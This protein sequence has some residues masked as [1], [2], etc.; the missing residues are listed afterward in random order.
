MDDSQRARD[1]LE[2]EEDDEFREQIEEAFK[3]FDTIPKPKEYEQYGYYDGAYS[4]M[5]LDELYSNM[6]IAFEL[7]E[8]DDKY[9]KCNNLRM[10]ANTVIDSIDGIDKYKIEL[11]PEANKELQKIQAELR[12]LLSADKT[13]MQAI[14]DRI[15]TYNNYAIDIWNDYLTNVNDAQNNEFRWVVHNLTKGELQGDFRDKYMSTSLITNNAMGLYGSANYGL[16]IKP[17]H[18]VSASHKD[19]YTNNF[20]D[21]DDDL[22]T[23]K[24][25]IKLPQ[26]VEETCVEKTIEENGE[27]LNYDT[28]AIYSE[29]V[30]DEY[31]I[32]G[33]YYISNGEHEL[34]RNYDRARKVAEEKG[35]PLIERDISKYRAEHGLDPM[36]DKTKRDFCKS[37]LFGCCNGY[38][39]LIENFMSYGADFVN[40]N[41]QE[42]YDKYM[43]LKQQ[44]N[45]SIED[46]LKVF[47]EIVENDLHF[48]E[49]AKNV[50]ELYPSQA[51][52]LQQT[53]ELTQDI[54]TESTNEKVEEYMK[55]KQEIENYLG[56]K[57]ESHIEKREAETTYGEDYIGDTEEW[58]LGQKVIRNNRELS[59]S[60]VKVL[61]K[62]SEEALKRLLKDSINK[63]DLETATTCHII[64]QE[65]STF[66]RN[67]P[68][69]I[70]LDFEQ[71]TLLF[72]YEQE[73]R[74]R[75]EQE[76]K[77]KAAQEAREK[78]EQKAREKAEQEAREKV[79]RE[80]KEKSEQ[81]ARAKAE[82]EAK[83]KVAQE[84]RAKAEQEAKEKA[85][86]EARTKAEQEAKEKL[87]QEEREK[88]EQ[89]AKEQAKREEKL[90]I[91]RE[92]EKEE[93][94]KEAERNE[95]IEQEWKEYT[96]W[97]NIIAQ[98]PELEGLMKE[99]QYEQFSAEVQGAYSKRFNELK[100]IVDELPEDIRVVFDR[101]FQKFVSLGSTENISQT[102][103][104]E[105]TDI[106]NE[107]EITQ[108]E[109]D[110]Q[111]QENMTIGVGKAKIN[112]FGEIIRDESTKIEG[113][114]TI[115]VEENLQEDIMTFEPP[116]SEKIRPEEE[117]IRDE[118]S[119]KP[120]N[121]DRKTQKKEAVT[122]DLWM[123]R[124][125]GWYNAIDRVSQNVK[126]KFIQM[127][128][129]IVNAIRDRLK[130]RTT[131]KQEDVQM[132]DTNE[133]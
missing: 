72:E 118:I 22:Y 121:T 90:R 91:E 4:D 35:L 29:I 52:K 3:K 130:E 123:S 12:I 131:Q 96:E 73:A 100:A 24:P 81:E 50:K 2:P 13:D 107:Q 40:A 65:E 80:A 116:Q 55:S 70:G 30:V 109:T 38:D 47:A 16:I 27:M 46:I 120:E 129:D 88:A 71:G 45:F 34:A 79:E 66:Y 7:R 102:T 106:T 108:Q 78:A 69:A 113:E 43:K 84:A 67:H 10:I 93:K 5:E 92:K 83:E 42:F 104:K 15:D 56:I 112:E 95:R 77:E 101:E 124:F 21:D 132:Q 19:T 25:A 54:M 89:E 97:E 33:V 20:R 85:E 94:K 87:E 103:N 51:D 9:Y 61:S 76:A 115:K 57:I 11:T 8:L 74:V 60:N 82:Q 26:E 68:N 28:E 114:D 36:T 41:Y 59:I 6:Q 32:E 23:I 48:G 39:S 99:L 58:I 86:Q 49:I 63:G 111:T 31:E 44:G 64:L 98:K 110:E 127:K 75:A 122:V 119:K 105:V 125:N 117:S 53:D 1:M 62:E 128:S 17:K 133:R 126:V 37:I 14:Q 18:I